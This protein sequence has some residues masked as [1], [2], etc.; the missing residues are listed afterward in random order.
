MILGAFAK[1]RK[2]SISLVMSV[3]ASVHKEQLGSY[4]MD[5]REILYFNIFLKPVEKIHVSVNSEENNGYFTRRPIYIFL[6][7]PAHFFLE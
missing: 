1:L 3:C 5:F 2:A 4:W 7:Y 6:S